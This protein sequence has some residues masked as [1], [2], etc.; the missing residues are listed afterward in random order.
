MSCGMDVHETT[1]VAHLDGAIA[2]DVWVGWR[3]VIALD[4]ATASSGW[5]GRWFLAGLFGAVR[6]VRG[7]TDGV[8][9]GW[10]SRTARRLP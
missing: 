2:E 9:R 7:R 10:V 4:S 1:Y 6:V 5:C 8:V 3:H